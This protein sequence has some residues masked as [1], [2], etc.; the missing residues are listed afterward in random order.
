MNQLPPDEYFRVIEKS[1]LVSIDLLVCKN[2]KY[3]VGKRT[4][5]PA[6]GFYF[7]PGCRLPKMMSWQSGVQQCAKYE[8][9]ITVRHAEFFVVSDHMYPNNFTGTLVPTHYVVIAVKCTLDDDEEVDYKVVRKQHDD[10][11]WLSPDEVIERQ[12]VHEFTKRYFEP[13]Q[14]LLLIS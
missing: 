2:N 6:K 13:D 9:G 10:Y 5:E 3:L 11:Q 12:D 8:L 7:V 4:N 14:K 1:Q